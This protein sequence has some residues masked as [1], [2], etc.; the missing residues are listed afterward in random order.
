MHGCHT[1]GPNVITPPFPEYVSGHSTFSAAAATVLTAFT[2][3]DRFGA[4]AVVPRGSSLVEPGATPS[5]DVTLT[6]PTFSAAADQAGI[7]R[8]YGGIHYRSGDL[9]GRR[10]GREVGALATGRAF[11]YLLGIR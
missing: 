1:S 6:W 10:L 11:G 4:S 5:A 9:A 2:G 7:S 8:R 3:S